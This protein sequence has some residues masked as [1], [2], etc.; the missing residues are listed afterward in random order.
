MVKDRGGTGIRVH[1]SRIFFIIPIFIL[2]PSL[3]AR[4]RIQEERQML[5]LWAA[6]S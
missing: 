3:A 4:L 6:A 5:L 1:Q 2:L